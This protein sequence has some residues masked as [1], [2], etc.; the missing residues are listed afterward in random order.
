MPD[1]Q[2]TNGS[3]AVCTNT[4]DIAQLRRLGWREVPPARGTDADTMDE[5]FDSRPLH[6][7]GG[8]A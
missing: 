6:V 5:R 7:S 3:R 4:H 1:F 2:S 8:L